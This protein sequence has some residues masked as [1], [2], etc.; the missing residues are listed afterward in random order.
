MGGGWGGTLC[1]LHTLIGVL[2]SPKSIQFVFLSIR[3]GC[4]AESRLRCLK[5]VRKKTRMFP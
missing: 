2:F 4:R 1:V 5:S 3:L